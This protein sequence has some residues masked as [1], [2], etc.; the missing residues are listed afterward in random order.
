MIYMHTLEIRPAPAIHSVQIQRI[1]V[2]RCH[3]Y[4]SGGL[5][6]RNTPEYCAKEDRLKFNKNGTWVYK[7]TAQNGNKIKNSLKKQ[8][9]LTPA[10]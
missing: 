3:Y 9:R 8:N 4:N 6:L 7:N 10:R 1:I 5:P 2:H